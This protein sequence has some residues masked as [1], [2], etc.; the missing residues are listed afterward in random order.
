M[1]GRVLFG[2]PLIAFGIMHF[3]NASAMTGFV[4]SYLGAAA[5]WVYL[6]GIALIL[7]GLSIIVNKFAD[8]AGFL[9]GVMLIV[10]V[11]TLHLPAVLGGDQA[12]MGSLLKDL[13]LAGAAFFIA[14]SSCK[15]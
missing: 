12:A 2:L 5:F 10:F 8:K 1:V 13:S 4:P 9:L 11:L 15:K 7:G 3:M 6:T 14:V